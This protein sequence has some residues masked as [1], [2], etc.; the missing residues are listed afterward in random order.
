MRRSPTWLLGLLAVLLLAAGCR[1][2][3]PAEPERPPEEPQRPQV[4]TPPTPLPAPKLQLPETPPS[5]TIL[6]PQVLQGEIAILALD[7]PVAG[8]VKVAVEGLQE[9]PRPFRREGRPVAFLG[10]PAN[11]RPGSYPV[12]VTWPGGAWEGS[13]EVL[14]KRFTE[15]RLVVTEEQRQLYYDPRQQEEWKRVFQLR[16]I[17][18]PHP[19]WSGPFRP[20]LEGEL[21]VT[22]Y[23]GEIRFVN[24][25]ETGRHSGMDFGAPTGTPI[26]AP[27]RGRVVLAEPLIVTGWTIIIDHG[28]N[29]FTTYYHCDRVDVK[30]GDWVEPGQA[31][32]TV[33]NTGF[34]TGPHL[35]WTATIGNTP[36]NPWPLTE[37]VLEV[38]PLRERQPW[39][40]EE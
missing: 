40:Q 8:E 11:A 2:G 39:E 23:F 30:P 6:P 16:S 29:L 19:L 22:T 20:P 10:F 12:R 7:R 38:L 3:P 33:G 1:A 35:H 18:E 25:V 17:T 34:S 21:K 36:V 32:G 26:L 27:A 13:V 37:G 4:S 31:I 28:M 14:P 5:A 24:G 9:Q 15:D